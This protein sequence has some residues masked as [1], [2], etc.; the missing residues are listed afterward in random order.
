MKYLK[1]FNESNF[2]PTILSWAEKNLDMIPI[3]DNQY[4]MCKLEYDSEKIKEFCEDNLAYL[5]DSGFYLT[6][7]SGSKFGDSNF[8]VFSV[9][10]R[11]HSGFFKWGEIVDDFVPFLQILSDRYKLLKLE[12]TSKRDKHSKKCSIIFNDYHY[13]YRYSLDDLVNDR[14]SGISDKK[15][16]SITFSVEI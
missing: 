8:P 6:Y 15:L 1:K 2:D 10:L 14:T 12:P 5:K 7:S 3:N 11:K 16:D 4:K 13:A 9:Y